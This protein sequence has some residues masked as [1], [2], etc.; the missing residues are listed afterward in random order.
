MK[1]FPKLEFPLIASPKLDGIRV[2]IIDGVAM[3]RNL[4]PVR[5]KYV[6]SIL[7]KPEYN[8]LDG[9]IIV[10]DP[11]DKLCYRNTNSGVMSGDGEPDFNFYVFDSYLDPSDFS[12]RLR[13]VSNRCGDGFPLR[14][15]DHRL[16]QSPD[17]LV[18]YEEECLAQGYEGIMLRQPNG[19]YKNGRSTLKEQILLKLKRFT[20]FEATIVGFQERM[21]NANE[22]KTNALGH[23]ERSMH[24]ENMIGRG[25]LGALV[26][27]VTTQA[28]SEGAPGTG[29]K[30][31][32]VMT[33]TYEFT[34]GSGFTDA[35][36]KEFWDNKEKYL[37]KMVT[38]RAFN[39]GGYD[40]PRFPTFVG[41]REDI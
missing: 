36:R 37:G 20:D 5:N 2:I 17:E 11:C 19:P 12:E 1:D 40:L 31:G 10:G 34:V 41:L 27:K 16:V 6:Q 18:R 33:Q 8:G 15:L 14:V 9:E 29:Q 21:H 39:Y 22:A 38:L 24:K 25:D 4:K 26:V 30:N 7:G 23:T 3:T 35:E 13:G 32:D 28:I